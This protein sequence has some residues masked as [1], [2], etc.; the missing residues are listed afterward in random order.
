TLSRDDDARARDHELVAAQ[1]I[2]TVVLD[3]WHRRERVP[4]LALSVGELV[5]ERLAVVQF[6]DDF[7]SST[8]HHLGAHVNRLLLE[9]PERVA[10]AGE[11]EHVVQKTDAAGRVH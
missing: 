10:A 1:Q 11:L 8:E 6:E 5:L 4:Y 9:I 2:D 7:G 3:R